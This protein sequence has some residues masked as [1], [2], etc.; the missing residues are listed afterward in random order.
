MHGI[1][2]TSGYVL[3]KD[4]TNVDFTRCE[5]AVFN[6]ANILLPGLELEKATQLCISVFVKYLFL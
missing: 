4:R 3:L 2:V 1:P 6:S 5:L